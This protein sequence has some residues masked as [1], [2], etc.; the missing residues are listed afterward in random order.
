MDANSSRS[1]SSIAKDLSVLAA[2]L[3]SGLISGLLFAALT[4]RPNLQTF[5]FIKADKFLIPRYTYWVAF[6]LILLAGFTAGYLVS[7]RRRWLHNSIGTRG[8]I[9]AA[10]SIIGVS[11]PLLRFI[12]PA[13]TVQF[14]LTWD[15]IIAPI[16]FLI[17]VSFAL[18]VLT[19]SLRLLPMAIVWNLIFATG[20][21]FVIYAVLHLF[22]IGSRGYEFVQWPILESMLALSYGNWI[23]W[24]QRVDHSGAA[25][26]GVGPERRQHVL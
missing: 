26:H 18:C 9:L 10:G 25:Q 1:P 7:C 23:I 3:I 13:M 20:A 4:T 8:H 24:R 2:F 12:T 22:N 6:G 16:T 21:F 14:G 5:W 17:L 19:G 15:F 11:A